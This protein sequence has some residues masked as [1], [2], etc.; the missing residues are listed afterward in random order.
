MDKILFKGV[1]IKKKIKKPRSYTIT[2]PI[3][4]YKPSSIFDTEYQN[5][6]HPLINTESSFVIKNYKSVDRINKT[7]EILKFC[8]CKSILLITKDKSSSYEDVDIIDDVGND[9]FDLKKYSYVIM[10]KCFVQCDI[11]Y[12][13]LTDKGIYEN[14]TEIKFIY[15]F[16]F[17][18]GTQEKIK[19]LV[20][21]QLVEDPKS[22][23]IYTKNKPELMERYGAYNITDDI[24]ENVRCK[25]VIFYDLC[26]NIKNILGLIEW[27]DNLT[28]FCIYTVDQKELVKEYI[29]KIEK[30]VCIDKQTLEYFKYK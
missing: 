21:D 23:I 22:A 17:I 12:I 28:I 16:K 11:P 15:R 4:N 29:N 30:F 26:T 8:N 13:I 10:D 18:N 27:S 14:I 9:E 3:P 20:I 1:D 7:I 25:R 19:H 2:N 24:S 5:I 6:I